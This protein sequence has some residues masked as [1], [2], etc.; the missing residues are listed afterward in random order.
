MKSAKRIV[1]AC[2]TATMAFQMLSPSSQA[3]A[4]EIDAVSSFSAQVAANVSDE[5]KTA[6]G[7][8]ESGEGESSSAGASASGAESGSAGAAGG[9][10]S[11][12][13]SGSSSSEAGAGGS[14]NDGAAS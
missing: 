3:L 7:G 9:A 2:L 6:Q 5:C 13:A 10:E 1:A 8:A 11:G 14:G 12:A 4:A